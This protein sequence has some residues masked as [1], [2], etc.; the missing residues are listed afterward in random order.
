[1]TS[2]D[3]TQ[4]AIEFALDKPIELINGEK[5]SKLIS[6]VNNN[7]RENLVS[8]NNSKIENKNI[9]LCPECNSPM[10]LRIAKHGEYAAKKFWGCP[11]YPKC[12]YIIPVEK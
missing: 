4:P 8:D 9:V 11:N 7:K 3:F 1:M 12:K 5:L 6:E 2:G 10:V